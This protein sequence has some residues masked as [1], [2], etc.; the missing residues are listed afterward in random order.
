MTEVGGRMVLILIYL[1]HVQPS[2]LQSMAEDMAMLVGPLFQR[3][4][5]Q[6]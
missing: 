1:H 2:I 5:Q 6:A 4:S 3:L